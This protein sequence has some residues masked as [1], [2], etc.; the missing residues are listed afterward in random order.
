[1]KLFLLNRVIMGFLNDRFTAMEPNRYDILSNLN[2]LYIWFQDIRIVYSSL[3]VGLQKVLENFGG[4]INPFLDRFIMLTCKLINHPL[5]GPRASGISK[6]E[7]DEHES[8]IK[9]NK[10]LH[11]KRDQGKY[12][13]NCHA[14]FLKNF[15]QC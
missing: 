10:Y 7:H 15:V 2:T 1:M 13:W 14:G 11:D 3:L 5:A 8:L 9:N 4:F 6:T 12:F